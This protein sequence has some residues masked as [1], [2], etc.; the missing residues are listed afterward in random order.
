MRSGAEKTINYAVLGAFA[1]IAV[2]PLVGLTLVAIQPGNQT[3]TGILPIPHY[4][5]LGNFSKAWRVAQ[6]S[7][8]LTT[9]IIIAAG[10][11]TI[12][13]L[14]SILAGY[15]FGTMRMR[16]SSWIFYLFL[17]GLIMPY[18]AI[19]V[20]LYYD[21]R[22]LSL[23]GTY[24]SLILPEAGLYLAFGTF[25]MR[26]FFRSVPRSL[27]EA[28][29]IDGA[30]SWTT[31]WRVL[32]PFGRPAVLTM[33]VL[34]FIWS[35]NEFLLPLVMFAGSSRQTATLAV[36]NFSGQYTTNVTL[37]TAAALI[38]TVPVL[39]VYVFFQRSFIRGMLSGA[40]KG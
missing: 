3:S 6:L 36:A 14:V 1:V 18:E 24:W 21:L 38:V 12:A 37:E 25:W 16:G 19:I 40:L 11:V 30:S 13:T 31:L 22:S 33:M 23:A 7:G 26:A 10:A 8:A 15:A 17:V 34:F 9:S 20:P 29:R 39:I 32:I 35:W 4:V 2:Y 28:A 27:I 5:S